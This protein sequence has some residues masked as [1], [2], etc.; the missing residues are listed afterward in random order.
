MS[1]RNH[2]ILFIGGTAAYAD[3]LRYSLEQVPGLK[4]E[5]RH[6][7]DPSQALNELSKSHIDLVF[8]SYQLTGKSAMEVLQSIQASGYIRPIIVMTS[9]GDE[10]GAS[11]MIRAGA[12]E[13]IIKDDLSPERLQRTLYI[14]EAQFQHRR[15]ERELHDKVHE[16]ERT[17]ARMS[18]DNAR[19]TV[20][21]RI[22][23]LTLLLNRRAWEES[24]WL[25]HQRARRSGTFYAI[26]M[27]DIDQFKVY[28][29]CLGH[30]RGDECL[31]RVATAIAD[32]CRCTDLVGRYGGEEFIM[33]VP[34]TNLDHTQVMAERLRQAVH[35]LA[36]DHPDS[37]PQRVTISLGIAIGSS[38]PWHT[39]T[40]RADEA[41]YRAKA[42][43]RNRVI[44]YQ[45]P[46]THAPDPTESSDKPSPIHRAS[47]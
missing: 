11:A 26:I 22:D 45:K 27:A 47:A 12:D 21:A 41:L 35:D 5:F 10:E 44:R 14:A 17:F 30:Q 46:T 40:A 2:V 28:N 8:L 31:R 33:L 19:L 36:I 13:F 20:S 39:I 15:G 3:L 9:L 42:D 7:V 23:P 16:L 34:E 24:A 43:G 37:D 1:A 29:D 25:E 38:E 4:F 18:S 6:H 32:T